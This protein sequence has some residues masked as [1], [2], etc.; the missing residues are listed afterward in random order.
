MLMRHCAGLRGVCEGRLIAFDRHMNL[1]LRDVTEWCTPFRTMANGGITLSKNQRRR[2]RKTKMAGSEERGLMD[3][4]SEMWRVRGEELAITEHDV[5]EKA[6]RERKVEKDTEERIKEKVEVKEER[7]VEK[8]NEEE[9]RKGEERMVEK[10]K[11][12]EK[13]VKKRSEENKWESCRSVRQVF[14][15]GD[16][17]V[18]ISHAL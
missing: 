18:L 2:R 17:V 3:Q 9:K 1:V 10:R 14:V 11:C 8:G 12:E 4:T 15:R 7:V 13:V 5:M 6:G 16:N